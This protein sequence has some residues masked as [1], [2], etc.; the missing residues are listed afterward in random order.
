MS[1]LADAVY[2]TLTG[3][4]GTGTVTLNAALPGYFGPAALSNAASYYYVIYDSDANGTPNGGR[5][6]GQGTYTA[7][8][9]TLSRDTVLKST[10]G[11]AAV[12]FLAGAR[13]FVSPPAELFSLLATLASPTFTGTPAG[14]TATPGTNTTQLATTA[15]ATAAAAAAQ[16]ASLPLHGTADTVTTNAN[17]TGPVTSVGNAT[18]IASGVVTEA[19][20]VLADNTTQNVSTTKH[21]Y[22]PKG[23]NVGNFLR[24][25]GTYAA[26]GG[27]VSS[28][29]S[30]GGTLTV[31][32]ATGAVDISLALAHANTWTGQQTFNTSAGIFGV[33]VG[34]GTSTFGT[35]AK[36]TVNPSITPDNAATVQVTTAQ[37]ADKCL[38]L[39]AHSNTQSGNLL[40]IQD[41]TGVVQIAI[42]PGSFIINASTISLRNYLNSPTVCAGEL[43]ALSTRLSYINMEGGVQVL[44][45]GAANIGLVV[46]A[47]A[48]QT[49]PLAQLQTSTGDSLGNVGTCAFDDFASVAT[50]HVDGTFDVLSTHTTVANSLQ[51]NGDKIEFDFTLTVVG[52]AVSTDQI[53]VAFGGITIFDSGANNYAL[54]ATIRIIGQIIRVSSTTCRAIVSFLPAGSATILGYE[55]MTY[56]S[57]STLTGMT[58]S[59]TNILKVQAAATGT[60]SAASDVTLTVGSIDIIPAGS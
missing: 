32:A 37:D 30:S 10:N 49:A 25:D 20:Q 39:Q 18:A 31:S 56:T 12:N 1:Q 14:P 42:L 55:L 5:E 38:V 23:T 33:G 9:T 58:L 34:I 11:N 16:A 52:H 51:I 15:F 44:T 47:A 27:G 24:D 46:Q 29:A 2:C 59:G 7:S 40:E 53:Q 13:M 17:L 35:V 28:L 36:L 43:Y 21:G 26:A 4:P 48:S 8:G 19:M 41:Y 54:A 22:A 57:D 3:T 50:T 6:I 45:N 60:N